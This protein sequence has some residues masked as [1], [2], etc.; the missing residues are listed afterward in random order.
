[1]KYE[2][3]VRDVLISNTIRLIA[4]GGFEKATTKAITHGGEQLPNVKMNE[5]YIYRLFGSKEDLYSFAFS[6]LD[7][8]IV[9]ALRKCF[10]TNQN[11]D[12]DIKERLHG[13][14]CDAWHFI[15]GNEDHCRCYIRY[16]YSVYFHGESL[17]AHNQ[18]FDEIILAFSPLFKEEADVKSIMHSVFTTILDFAV[19]VYNGDLENTQI[20]EEHIFN[21][22]Y[23]MMVTYFKNEN[24]IRSHVSQFI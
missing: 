21:V 17:K 1:M 24:T 5:V 4:E 6:C 9:L 10:Q 18:L 11:Q 3:E 15:L 23:C 12:C 20:N 22:V 14:F 19:R 13:V 8:E 7:K 2:Q 16:Y